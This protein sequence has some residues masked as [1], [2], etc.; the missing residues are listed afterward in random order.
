MSLSEAAPRFIGTPA[1]TS[2]V[3]AEMTGSDVDTR[4]DIYS[5]GV[6]LY[7]LLTGVTPFDAQELTQSGLDGMRRVIR[8]VEPPTP[9][10]RLRR[11]LVGKP[12]HQGSILVDRDLDW[13]VMKCLEKDRAR[14][15][16]T[17]QELATDLQRYLS[18][19]PVLARPQSPAYRLHKAVRRHRAAFA[20]AAA[21]LMAV[22]GSKGIMLWDVAAAKPLRVLERSDGLFVEP[23]GLMR[24]KNVLLF[25][26]DG[27]SVIAARNSLRDASVFV[28]DVWDP[29]TGG[30]LASIPAQRN[31]IDHSGTISSVAFAPGGQLLASASWHHSIRLWDFGTRPR[32]RPTSV[33]PLRSHSQMTAAFSRLDP[34]R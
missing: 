23:G 10:T 1:Y 5:L 12:A 3:Q 11:A 6:L 16:S 21:I 4:S 18:Q 22:D 17:A 19:E 20:A 24:Y 15:Y 30:K 2:P 31:E 26:P 14:R 27:N 33:S 32:S 7:E 28:I 29:A 13:I 25:S 9:S 8:D 34:I